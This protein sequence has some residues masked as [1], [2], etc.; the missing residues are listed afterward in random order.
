[1][2]VFLLSFYC[3]HCQVALN[4]VGM[5]RAGV[6]GAK[7]DVDSFTIIKVISGGYAQT[8][9]IYAWPSCD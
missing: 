1:M 6:L 2:V 4:F 3:Y 7:A 9:V 8:L 5:A